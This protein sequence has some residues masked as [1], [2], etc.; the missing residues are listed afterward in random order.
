MN[1][2]AYQDCLLGMLNRELTKD[3]EQI[4]PEFFKYLFDEIEKIQVKSLREYSIKCINNRL[5]ADFRYFPVPQIKFL[6]VPDIL[7]IELDISGF[8]GFDVQQKLNNGLKRALDTGNPNP[9]D[10]KK[11][12]DM[13]AQIDT[14][15]KNKLNSGL[16]RTIEN[17]EPFLAKAWLS[18]GAMIPDFQQRIDKGLREANT[19]FS[20]IYWYKLGESVDDNFQLKLNGWLK[21][22]LELG[23]GAG[24]RQCVA[25]GANTENLQQQMDDGMSSILDQDKP[26]SADVICWR[27]AGANIK[28]EYQTILDSN[29]LRVARK[30]QHN[31]F[32][33]WIKLG[34]NETDEAKQLM[35]LAA[36]RCAENNDVFG[37]KNWVDSGADNP[38]N[39]VALNRMF[40]TEVQNDRPLEAGIFLTL[41]AKVS[42]NMQANLDT[43]L[44]RAINNE[45]GVPAIKN[46]LAIGARLSPGPVL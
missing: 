2:I 35:N 14:E 23:H 15:V 3:S 46:W 27:K 39:P 18:L 38:C 10:L 16:T 13:G 45:H 19:V 29:L 28:P 31:R 5:K 33:L 12:L 4:S 25:M 26:D 11:W 41:G 1:N 30:Y 42:S 24:V 20:A 34:A 22:Y 21:G 43:G 6:D 17:K 7:K 9:F 36:K 37:L 40:Q 32:Q 8:Y 44:L